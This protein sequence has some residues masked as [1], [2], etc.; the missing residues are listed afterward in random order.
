MRQAHRIGLAAAFLMLAVTADVAEGAPPIV[1]DDFTSA[2]NTIF[3]TDANVGVFAPGSSTTAT[4]TG[5][6][7]VIG[8]TRELTVSAD[9]T[10]G[11]L[12]G[13]DNVIVGVVPLVGFLDYNS[14]AAA[15]GKAVLRYN[16][17]GVGLNASLSPATGIRLVT[18]DADLAAVPIQVT[19]TLVDEANNSAS[20]SST[21]FI[22]G[23]TPHIDFPFASFPGVDPQ[24]IFSI[25]LTIDPTPS[26]AADLRLDRIETYSPNTRP[27]T[28]APLLSRGMLVA[29]VAALLLSARRRLV[30]H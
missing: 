12:V 22:A 24:A 4:D 6:T 27:P 2:Q 30:S 10:P 8:G 16:G 13:L 17:G 5:L 15:E 29:L 7:D 18:L 19:L 11:F 23:T 25:E 9:N 1:I 20:A 14:T 3:I 26:G 21:V 28:P